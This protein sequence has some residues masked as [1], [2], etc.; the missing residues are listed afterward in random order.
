MVVSYWIYY[1]NDINNYNEIVYRIHWLAKAIVYTN[2][3]T[4]AHNA[5][6]EMTSLIA[7]KR[8]IDE[9]RKKE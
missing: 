6:V 2:N 4:L 5:C 3:P 1:G 8:M 9:S 7:L